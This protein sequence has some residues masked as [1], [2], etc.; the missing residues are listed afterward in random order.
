MT[1]YTPTR[2]ASEGV[3]RS[4]PRWRVGLVFSALIVAEAALATL[5]Q[6]D[7]PAIA[8]KWLKATAYAVPKE[9]APEGEGYFSIVTGLDGKLYIGT[10]ANAVNAWLVEFDPKTKQMKTVVDAHKAIGTDLKGFGAQAKIHTR[11]NVGASG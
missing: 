11:N 1:R 3:H 9:T 6:A 4:H 5:V 8:R 2:R 7:E 10:H